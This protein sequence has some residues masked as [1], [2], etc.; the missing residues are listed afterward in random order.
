MVTIMGMYHIIAVLRTHALFFV[1]NQTGS[2][3]HKINN[4]DFSIRTFRSSSAHK[5]SKLYVMTFEK[6]HNM[7]G[8]CKSHHQQHNQLNNWPPNA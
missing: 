1:L 3:H 7:I 6:L 4:S 2:H 8:L 5:T